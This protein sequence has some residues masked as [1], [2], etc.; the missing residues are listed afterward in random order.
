MASTFVRSRKNDTQPIRVYYLI[1]VFVSLTPITSVIH[2]I[3]VLKE[4]SCWLFG[5][6]SVLFESATLCLPFYSNNLLNKSSSHYC[7][8]RTVALYEMQEVADTR[9]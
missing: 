6:I 2:Y 3:H 4:Y 5:S 7:L 9:I 8:A 1:P